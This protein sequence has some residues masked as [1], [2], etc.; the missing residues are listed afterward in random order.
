MANSLFSQFGF[1]DPNLQ[2]KELNLY[3][4]SFNE[5]RVSCLDNLQELVK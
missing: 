1:S 3:I 5:N 4:F 2:E